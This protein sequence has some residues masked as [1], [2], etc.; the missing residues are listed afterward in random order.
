[1]MQQVHRGRVCCVL[2]ICASLA[3]AG[4]QTRWQ[5]ALLA[6]VA[7]A[8]QQKSEEAAAALERRLAS[9][10]LREEL[11]SCSPET[12][13]LSDSELADRIRREVSVAEVISGF[14]AAGWPG[15]MSLREGIS[16]PPFFE[17]NWQV[18]VRH[19]SSFNEGKGWYGIQDDNE[20]KL[21]GLRP[22]SHHGFPQTMQEAS[23]RAPYCM[24]NLHR[25]DSGSQLYGDVSVVFSP[26]LIADAS[27]ISSVDTGGWAAMCNNTDVADIP[28][29][30][31]TQWPWPPPGYNPNCSAY[32][33]F[34][35]LGTFKSFDQLFLMNEA[36][37]NVSLSHILCRLLGPWGSSPVSGSDLIHYWEAM[38]IAELDYVSGV[39]FVIAAFPSL[40][41]TTD[42]AQLQRWCVEKGWVL[43]WSLG[44]NLGEAEVN[45]WTAVSFNTK[46]TSN[47]RLADPVVLVQTTAA[48]NMSLAPQVMEDYKR[49]WSRARALREA[50][51][52]LHRSVSNLTWA[53]AWQRL[54]QKLPGSLRLA[55]LRSG[56]CRDVEGC[57][58]TTSEG[59]CLCYQ[60]ASASM[61]V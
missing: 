54:D 34:T 21:Y 1:M 59:Q 23:E 35:G 61:V 42:G 37:W 47:R 28:V 19:N 51:S 32:E 20:V 24:V 7:K 9:P 6:R 12:S 40:F 2:L 45:F 53:A 3:R 8:A 18:G 57:I 14:P 29:A 38:P 31:S 10:A 15:E 22:F 26:H 16:G 17:S 41:G 50:A 39:K 55:P 13:L 4:G 52:T 11:N 49:E 60:M 5:Q 44:L 43:V 33:R 27:V 46:F 58:G 56:D 48:N 30:T 36:Y 25:L